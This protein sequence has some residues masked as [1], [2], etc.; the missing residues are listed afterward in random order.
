ML[1]KSWE[2]NGI[3]YLALD[4]GARGFRDLDDAEV[5]PLP[6]RGDLPV[7]GDFV[8]WMMP[9]SARSLL[10][11]ICRHYNRRANRVL[12]AIRSGRPQDS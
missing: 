3:R 12:L 5:R 9:R 10:A 1:R 8:A 4:L 2:G 6:A 11:G 7:L